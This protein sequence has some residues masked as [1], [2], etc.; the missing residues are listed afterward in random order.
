MSE[1]SVDPGAHTHESLGVGRV[2]DLG[3]PLV[4]VVPSERMGR[5]EHDELGTV[6]IRSFF[7]TLG[8]VSPTP[9]TVLFFNS[10]VKL[11]AEGSP[12]VEELQALAARDV[13]ILA[14]GTC[15]GYYA[16]KDKV[17]V[18]EVSNM[19]TIAERMLGADKVVTL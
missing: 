3:G 9:D 12:L 8:E 4:L 2:V 15:L 19:Y 18:G 1:Q 6:L 11:V 17:A 16:L 13:E 7:H 10:G 14:C 5:G